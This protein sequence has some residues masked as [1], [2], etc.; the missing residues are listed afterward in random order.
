MPRFFCTNRRDDL[1]IMDENDSRHMK[2]SLRMKDGD[3]ITVCDTS[4]YDYECRLRFDDD[5][6]ALC[7]I[8]S[9]SE[10]DTEPTVR[11][12]LYQAMPK[13]DKFEQIVRKCVEIGVDEIVPVMTNRC[14]SRPKGKSL[15]KKIERYNRISLSAAKQSGRGKIPVV[16]EMI[17]F[18]EAV[19][20]LSKKELPLMFYENGGES[21]EEI[22][23]AGKVEIGMMIGSEGGFDLEEVASARELGINIMS[24][25][26]RILRCETAPTV[27]LSA[28]MLITGNL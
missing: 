12:T 14:V 18:S 25:G 19:R 11:V 16:R 2:K 9:R 28:V 10:N 23:A 26:K 1:F 17:D 3:I 13:G 8:L 22:D 24:L 27:A 20:E 5:G 15:E 7:S 6:T 4:G 21:L